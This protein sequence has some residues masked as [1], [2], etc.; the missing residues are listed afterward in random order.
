MIEHI[1]R[2]VSFNSSTGEAMSN[3]AADV[4]HA[5]RAS[6]REALGRGLDEAI[7]EE[8]EQIR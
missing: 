1:R 5:Q 6:D 7:W 4:E 8:A 3:N 2:T